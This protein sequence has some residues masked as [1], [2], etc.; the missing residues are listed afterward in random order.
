[1]DRKAAMKVALSRREL[2]GGLGASMLIGPD[3]ARAE[4]EPD[5]FWLDRLKTP[6]WSELETAWQPVTDRVMGGRSDLSATVETRANRLCYRMRGM[7]STANNGG[8]IQLALPLARRGSALDASGWSGVRLRV[9]GNGET[10]AV[11]LRS[12]QSRAPWDYFSSSFTAGTE[13]QWVD[14]PFSSF[15][16]S[17]GSQVLDS[18]ALLRLAVVGIGRD[19]SADLSVADIGLVADR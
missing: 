1:M 15:V 17:N 14:L 19:F 13:W 5:V 7:V 9:L 2:L 12:S 18:S 11:H 16:H 6:G 10:Y 4:S 3:L 8:F